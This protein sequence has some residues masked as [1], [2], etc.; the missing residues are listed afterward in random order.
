MNYFCLIIYDLIPEDHQMCMV[1]MEKLTAEQV[2]LL[3][4]VA[5]TV[6]NTTDITSEQEN[7][8][9]RLG[10][11]LAKKETH[12]PPNMP[13]SEKCCFSKYRVEP[14]DLLSLTDKQIVMVVWAAFLL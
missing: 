3:N 9:E 2:K 1:P 10:G 13:T 5:S 4:V 12:C 6:A 11:W 7:A 14:R 8:H